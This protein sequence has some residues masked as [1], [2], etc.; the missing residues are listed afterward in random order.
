MLSSIL[1]KLMFGHN[2]HIW[3]KK[4]EDWT[5][6]NTLSNVEYSGCSIM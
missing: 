2:D 5:P 3:I 4:K 6:K 1:S